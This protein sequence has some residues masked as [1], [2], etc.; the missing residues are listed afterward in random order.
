MVSC[1]QMRVLTASGLNEQLHAALLNL[2]TC[3]LASLAERGRGIREA[4][5]ASSAQLKY[6]AHNIITSKCNAERLVGRP[7]TTSMAGRPRPGSKLKRL[8]V[9]GAACAVCSARAGCALCELA[10]PGRFRTAPLGHI[11]LDRPQ[12]RC[13]PACKQAR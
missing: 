2:N 12:F 13:E 1:Y 10:Q 4:S 6:R 11:T 5:L 8:R 7:G 9:A 3:N